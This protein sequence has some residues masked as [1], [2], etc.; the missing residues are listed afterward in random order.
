MSTNNKIINIVNRE[1]NLFF[2]K[3]KREF[4]DENKFFIDILDSLSE[5]TMRGGKRIRPILASYGYEA[6]TGKISK[7]VVRLSIFLELIQSSLLIHDDIIDQDKFRRGGQTMHEKYSEYFS[8]KNENF[9]KSMAI[10]IGDLAMNFA[11]EIISDSNFTNNIKNQIVFLVSKY[12]A[13]VDFGQS[14]DIKLTYMQKYQEKDIYDIHYFK[15]M[16]YTT[17]MPLMV[18]ATL[19]NANDKQ[20]KH[21][22]EYAKNTG[23]AF[24]IQDDIMGLFGDEKKLGKPIGSDLSENKKTLLLF[25][26]YQNASL[27]EQKILSSVV[28]SK[29]ITKLQLKEVRNI[30]VKTKSLQYSQMMARKYINKSIKIIKKSFINDKVKNKLIKMAHYIIDRDK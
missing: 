6:V 26:A 30:V 18:G 1:L 29:K 17:M 4:R 23:I 15:T 22:A 28:G 13:Q 2:N 27:R 7:D 25:K 24:Q 5:Y 12:I 11:F 9:G 20:K 21:I 16:I 10:V 3:K 8:Q 14:M 19:G